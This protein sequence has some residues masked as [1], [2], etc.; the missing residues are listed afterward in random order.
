M[1]TSFQDAPPD[2]EKSTYKIEI[3]FKDNPIPIEDF[4]KKEG[5][6][7]VKNKEL[8]LKKWILRLHRY[9]YLNYTP[10]QPTLS[11][12]GI[13]EVESVDFFFKSD[14]GLHDILFFKLFQDYHEWNEKY[15]RESM[16]NFLNQFY[17]L[18]SEGK[19]PSTILDQKLPKK[20]N[21]QLSLKSMRFHA[22]RPLQQFC[23]VLYRSDTFPIGLIKE[24]YRKYCER[25]FDG[26]TSED[27]S[28]FDGLKFG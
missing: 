17:E 4:S 8:L 26:F 9:K 19:D 14:T 5:Y 11:S 6:S 15:F 13:D 22:R 20:S 25:Y 18:K 16:E 1:K 27:Q 21:D 3:Y 23:L 7:E 12:G 28:F 10:G 2:K 24:F